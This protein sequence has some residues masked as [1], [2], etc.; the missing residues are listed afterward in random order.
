MLGHTHTFE[1][2]RRNEYLFVVHLR[3][4][5]LKTCDSAVVYNIKTKYGS[6]LHFALNFYVNTLFTFFFV[7][8]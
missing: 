6:F 7:F 5:K 8:V 2:N 1:T 4:H 3:S